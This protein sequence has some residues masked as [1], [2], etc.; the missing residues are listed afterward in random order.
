VKQATEVKQT[1]QQQPTFTQS[2][3][4]KRGHVVVVS[5]IY[6]ERSSHQYKNGKNNCPRAI[7]CQFH[8]QRRAKWKQTV[9]RRWHFNQMMAYVDVKQLHG[10]PLS[11][12]EHEKDCLL[13]RNPDSHDLNKNECGAGTHIPTI[14]ARTKARR[15]S[16]QGCVKGNEGESSCC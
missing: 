10:F 7:G 13:G 12:Q 2:A 3:S 4:A 15:P 5:D 9:R 6:M 16:C 1:N 11:S 14:T 8:L